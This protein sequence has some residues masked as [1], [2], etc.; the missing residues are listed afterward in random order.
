MIE[1]RQH[2]GFALESDQPVGMLRDGI[3]QNLDRCL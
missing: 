3:G 1:R 2:L